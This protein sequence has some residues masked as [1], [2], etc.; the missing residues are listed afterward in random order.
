[1][2]IAWQ[3]ELWLLHHPKNEHCWFTVTSAGTA[4]RL[5]GTHPEAGEVKTSKSVRHLHDPE[6]RG[7]HV[8]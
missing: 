6:E 1:V 2:L 4:D 3:V 5:F 7:Q 8:S